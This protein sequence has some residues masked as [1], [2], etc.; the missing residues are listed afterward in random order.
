[1]R[2]FAVIA[3]LLVLSAPAAAEPLADPGDEYAAATFAGGCFWCVEH[4]YDQVDGVVRTISGYTDGDER[5]PTYSQVAAGRTGH[6]EAVR[7]VYD[8]SAVSYERL[9]EVFWYN[10]D[11][12]V[13]DRQF[14]D[15]GSQY[16]TGIFYHDDEQ[17]RLAERSR[18]AIADS[19]I[20]PAPIVT[21]IEPAGDFWVAEDYHQDYHRK[22]PFRYKFYYSACGRED[23][24]EELWGDKAGA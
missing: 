13:S 9:L 22:N 5:N 6:T 17:R 7:V 12:T 10:I 24:L 23:R 15:T 14:C 11:P 19:G 8:P 4:A 21:P 20:L 18:D 1:M 16:R 2:I 3:C